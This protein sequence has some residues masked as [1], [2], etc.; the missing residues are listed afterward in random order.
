M[1]LKI[2]SRFLFFIVVFHSCGSPEADNHD[3]A[4]LLEFQDQERLAHLRKDVPLMVEMLHDTV[5]QIKGGKVTWFTKAEMASRFTQYFSM[6][7]FIKWED[8]SP[9]VVTMSDDH[10]L[11]HI[12]VQRHVELTVKDSLSTVEKTD[13]AWT[14]LW[15]KK[16]GRWRLYTIATTDRPGQ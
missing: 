15:K 10:S 6:V 3:V 16:N 13:F 8:S 2:T 14:E 1:S 12:L 7:D 5:C 4:A 11:A 9:P